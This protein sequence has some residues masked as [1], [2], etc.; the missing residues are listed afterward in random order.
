MKV[1]IKM[2]VKFDSVA[3]SCALEPDTLFL[4]DFQYILIEGE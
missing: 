2:K 4:L 1:E 3:I